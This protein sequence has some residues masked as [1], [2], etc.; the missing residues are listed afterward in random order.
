MGAA[1]NL[2]AFIFFVCVGLLCKWKFDLLY[3]S[4]Y[5]QGLPLMTL[6]SL[7]DILAIVSN[8]AMKGCFFIGELPAWLAE[9]EVII[10]VSCILASG[11]SFKKYDDTRGS[12]EN[13]EDYS[14][15]ITRQEIV[16]IPDMGILALP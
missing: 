11:L 8:L 4:F 9:T 7:V 3:L 13:D 1:G 14:E 5:M 2:W 6:A 16:I 10:K 12:W 15:N